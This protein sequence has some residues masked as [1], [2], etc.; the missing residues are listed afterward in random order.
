[1]TSA[2][3]EERG[4]IPGAGAVG[5]KG[6]DRG[7]SNYETITKWY[8]ELQ[9]LILSAPEFAPLRTLFPVDAPAVADMVRLF[10]GHIRSILFRHDVHPTMGHR[11]GDLMVIFDLN[12]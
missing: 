8:I 6:I 4:T 11:N 1:M 7:M 12:A 10:D 9:A 2:G 3:N 5:R